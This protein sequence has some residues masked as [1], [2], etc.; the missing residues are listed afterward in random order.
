[1]DF[2]FIQNI[3]TKNPVISGLKGIMISIDYLLC[4]SLQITKDNTHF[5][6]KTD[7][8]AVALKNMIDSNPM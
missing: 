3:Q 1:M 6:Q 8:L 2:I 5:Q 7:K 4:F